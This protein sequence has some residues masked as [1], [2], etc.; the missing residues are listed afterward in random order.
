M[1][2]IVI[3]GG[4]AGMLAAIFAARKGEEVIL[5]E[6]NEKL[7]KKLF[8]TGK[9]RC[10]ITN[11]CDIEDL[12][13]SIV[14]NQKFM[15]SSFYSFSNYDIIN[16]F[17]ELALKTKVERG[18]RVFPRSDK[19]SDVISALNKELNR[20]KVSIH[21]NS[22]VTKI[23]TKDNKFIAVEYRESVKEKTANK[24]SNHN[25]KH[26][27][28]TNRMH[29]DKVII[30]TGG[31]SYPVTGSTGDGYKFAKSMGHAITKPYPAL[32]PFNV[33]ESHIIKDLQGLSLKNI[34]I[35][36]YSKKKEIYKEFGELLFTHFGVSG[37]VILSASSYCTSYLPD[38]ELLLK[39][40]LKPGLS[41]EQLDDRILRDFAEVSN[42][43]FKNSLDKLLPRKL[44]PVIIS[45]SKINPE[46]QVNAITRE[47]RQELVALI[48]G[49]EFHII[50]T[51]D[52]KEAIITQ[53]GIDIR[54]VNPSTM[55]SK[56]ISGVYFAG[57]VL[58]IDGLTGGYNLQIAWS[59]GYL[60][61][62][63]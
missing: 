40:D 43:Q 34:E 6:K 55:E 49:L 26:S 38:N 16:F 33:K 60:A 24:T 59:T 12:F 20:L 25:Q 47:E 14:S 27:T 39:I 42:K 37:P 32:V 36:I 56:L 23:I 8:I 9:G 54:Q 31:I 53:G 28:D 58:D 18:N 51:R 52:F 3:G 50:S 41:N 10:N 19:S 22:E 62:R 46:K 29:A 5:I 4:P 7:G 1:K 21:L 11:A 2:V 30:A 57:E 13:P 45:L 48:K 61:G 17:E 44:I 63:E 15:Y 35:K